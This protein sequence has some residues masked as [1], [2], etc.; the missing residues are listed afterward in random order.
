MHVKQQ[1]LI[2]EEIVKVLNNY[3]IL[4]LDE[5][6][7]YD[8]IGLSILARFVELAIHRIESQEEYLTAVKSIVDLILPFWFDCT[9]ITLDTA[10]LS[11]DLAYAYLV[12]YPSEDG[13]ITE[14]A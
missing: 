8:L 9:N 4:N 5:K 12:N 2:L 1:F 13:K 10:N 11:Y 6:F 3:N 14:E 7:G